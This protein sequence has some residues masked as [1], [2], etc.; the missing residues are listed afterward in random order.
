MILI[1]IGCVGAYLVARKLFF[2]ES[3]AIA[4][5]VAEEVFGPH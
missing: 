5:V 1:V 3:E 2:I 4:S